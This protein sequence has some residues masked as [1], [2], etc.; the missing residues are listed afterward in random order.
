VY[1]LGGENNSIYERFESDHKLK[2]AIRFCLTHKKSTSPVTPS[3]L[4]DGLE[5]IEHGI[6][7]NFKPM[8]AKALYERYT[9]KDGVIYDFACG[10][11][12]RML[13]ALSSK[14]NYKYYGVEPNT[15]TY[16]NLMKLGYRIEE[17]K[18]R[19]NLFKIKCIG[20]ES[21][22]VKNKESVDFAFSSPPYFSLEQYCDEDTQCYIKYPTL[23]KWFKGYVEPTIKNIY[24]LLKPGSYYAVNIADFKLGKKT[25]NFVDEWINISKNEGFE[26]VEQIHM[27]LQ[28]RRGDGH[29]ENKR[30]KKEGIFVFKKTLPG[31]I[32]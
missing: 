11:G 4:K 16:K 27:K 7:T 12:G 23:D 30:N 10:F 19:S 29:G 9:P 6:A 13:G 5:M 22:D 25:V 2:K 24:S 20:S 1:C 26:Y 8:N 3:G 28:T 14:N 32:I 17:V 15:E 21:I 31:S 18:R